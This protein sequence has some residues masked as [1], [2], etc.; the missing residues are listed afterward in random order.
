MIIGHLMDL[1]VKNLKHMRKLKL[2][3]FNLWISTVFFILMSE[4]EIVYYMDEF[5][6]I[7]LS[8]CLK[9]SNTIYIWYKI[10][11]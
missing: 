6:E 9:N 4:F 3:H 1:T 7:H 10:L 5:I 8:C 11:K 2:K